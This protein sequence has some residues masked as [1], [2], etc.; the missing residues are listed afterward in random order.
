MIQKRSFQKSVKNQVYAFL[1]LLVFLAGVLLP[2]EI[3]AQGMT[4]I[5]IVGVPSVLSS[6]YADQLEA[7]FRNGRYQVVFN[8]TNASQEETD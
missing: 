5:N 6:P 3:S 7:D 8:Y 1:L 4:R 2:T